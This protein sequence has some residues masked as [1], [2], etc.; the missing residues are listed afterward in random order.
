M[1][2]RSTLLRKEIWSFHG[3]LTSVGLWLWMH[4]YLDGLFRQT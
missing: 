4:G 1:S 2:Y 3:L